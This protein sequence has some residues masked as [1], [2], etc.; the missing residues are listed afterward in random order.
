L[1]QLLSWNP[2]AKIVRNFGIVLTSIQNDSQ[3]LWQPQLDD[4]QGNLYLVCYF[5]LWFH[6]H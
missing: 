5:R 1:T 2:W 3:L 6:Q 4:W